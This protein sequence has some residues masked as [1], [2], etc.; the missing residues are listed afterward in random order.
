MLAAYPFEEREHLRLSELTVER[1]HRLANR[2]LADIASAPNSP[3]Y[4]IV[5]IQRGQETVI[6][7]GSTVILPG[8]VLILAQSEGAKPRTQAGAAET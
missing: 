5:L 2:T 1:G 8:D 6:P 4:L 7:T 3:K